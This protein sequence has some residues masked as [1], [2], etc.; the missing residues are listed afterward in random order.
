MSEDI[1]IQFERAAQEVTQLSK[2]PENHMKLRLYALYKQATK[3]DN[4]QPKPG[5]MDFSAKVK[6]EAWQGL[7][8]MSQDDA[9]RAY[10]ALVEELK[11]ADTQ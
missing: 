6:H 4:H 10:I 1:Q 5:M 3:G 11:A 9:R 7:A 8:G 2:A